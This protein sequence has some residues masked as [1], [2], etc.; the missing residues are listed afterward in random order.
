MHFISY[1]SLCRYWTYK[2][3]LGNWIFFKK[4]YA[5]EV[6]YIPNFFRFFLTDCWCDLW[7]IV[8]GVFFN[9]FVVGEIPWC[10]LR[11]PPYWL[12]C[13][14]AYASQRMIGWDLS[15]TCIVTSRSERQPSKHGALADLSRATCHVYGIKV[16]IKMQCKRDEMYVNFVPTV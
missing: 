10:D 5:V 14:T 1:V 8:L 7:W 2:C 9:V 6:F 16:D 3:S 4:N 11:R 13:Q 15:C 12:Y